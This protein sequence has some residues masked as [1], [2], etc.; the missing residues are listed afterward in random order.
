MSFCSLTKGITPNICRQCVCVLINKRSFEPFMCHTF[1]SLHPICS[2]YV[3]AQNKQPMQGTYA[4]EGTDDLAQE[5]PIACHGTPHKCTY[6]YVSVR[7]F[8]KQKRQRQS[9][10]H[11]YHSWKSWGWTKT[12]ATE[13][14]SDFNYTKKKKKEKEETTTKR[15]WGK[16][17]ILNLFSS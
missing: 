6:L 5:K 14:K 11:F 10:R 15:L 9:H 4:C 1:Y 7:Y 3:W 17:Q 12:D 2:L 16:Q 8:N 13:F